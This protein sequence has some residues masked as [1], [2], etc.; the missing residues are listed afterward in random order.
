MLMEDVGEP[1]DVLLQPYTDTFDR[2]R[3]PQSPPDEERY[4]D[5]R[6]AS[7]EFGFGTKWVLQTRNKTV[8]LDAIS[9]L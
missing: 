1:D 2:K 3:R 9:N 5:S 8:C 7:E 6:V 4:D